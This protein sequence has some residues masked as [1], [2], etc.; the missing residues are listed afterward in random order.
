VPSAAEHNYDLWQRTNYRTGAR[1]RQD[2]KVS[3]CTGPNYRFERTL[4]RMMLK[5]SR[6]SHRFGAALLTWRSAQPER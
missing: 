5:V 6:Q 2:G 1:L 3:T 4:L